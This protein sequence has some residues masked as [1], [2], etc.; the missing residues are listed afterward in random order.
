MHKLLCMRSSCNH[1]NIYATAINF[2]WSPWAWAFILFRPNTFS[3]SFE[4]AFYHNMCSKWFISISIW[5]IILNK[6]L[7]NNWFFPY[8]PHP[9]FEAILFSVATHFGGKWQIQK[10]FWI[11]PRQTSWRKINYSVNFASMTM[12]YNN[13]LQIFFHRFKHFSVSI[14]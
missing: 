1:F 3:F 8:L 6:L 14:V 13:V 12:S 4:I 11:I 5:Y 7:F 2:H 10:A 9:I